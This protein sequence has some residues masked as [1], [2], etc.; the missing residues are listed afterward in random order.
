MILALLLKTNWEFPGGLAAKEPAV[1]LLWC[2]FDPQPE[3]FHM[4]QAQPKNPKNPSGHVIGMGLFEDSQ[5]YSL[6]QYVYHY[7]STTL[8]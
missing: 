5:F 2:G 4:P 1:S 7:A 8:S 6:D 3:K